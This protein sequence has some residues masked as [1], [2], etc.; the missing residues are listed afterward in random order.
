MVGQVNFQELYEALA[1]FHYLHKTSIL[2]ELVWMFCASLVRN[3]SKFQHKHRI[4]KIQ[5]GQVNSRYD[6]IT[7]GWYK[8]SCSRYNLLGHL[9]GCFVCAFCE[10]IFLSNL[11]FCKFREV[12]CAQN[13][14]LWINLRHE[15][16][17]NKGNLV[18]RV[19]YKFKRIIWGFGKF[20]LFTQ[21]LNNKLPGL[22]VLC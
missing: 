19:V 5:S 10:T 20:S 9:I 4:F 3:R 6:I 2:N 1:N 11:T 13:K 15:H 8:C 18:K 14:W 17:E 7:R 22:G 12:N 21:N 16:G